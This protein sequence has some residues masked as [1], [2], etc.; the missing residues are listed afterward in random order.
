MDAWLLTIMVGVLCA[1][2]AL[3]VYRITGIPGPQGFQGAR[4]PEGPTGPK[5]DKSV[6]YQGATGPTG[7]TGPTGATGPN[8]IVGPRG[9]TGITGPTGSTGPTGPT[10]P[11]DVFWVPDNLTVMARGAEFSINATDS[12]ETFLPFQGP[13]DN[14]ACE[15]LSW[16]GQ[17]FLVGVGKDIY[18]L[19]G[20]Q[21]LGQTTGSIDPNAIDT[22]IQTVKAVIRHDNNIVAVGIPYANSSGI[23]MGIVNADESVTFTLADFQPK[24]DTYFTALA[25]ANGIWVACSNDNSTGDEADD[26][27]IWKTTDE[28]ILSG[29][30]DWLK[31]KFSILRGDSVIRRS[32]ALATDGRKWTLGTPLVSIYSA[33]WTSNDIDKWTSTQDP[34]WTNEEDFFVINLINAYSVAYNGHQWLAAGNGFGTSDPCIFYKD[35][36]D[37][38]WHPI[39]DSKIRPNGP[40]ECAIAWT[41][42]SWV[43]LSSSEF[44]Y[45]L[46]LITNN[47]IQNSITRLS[48]VSSPYSLCSNNVWSRRP[49]NGLDAIDT[50]AH[51]NAMAKFVPL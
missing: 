31:Y 42:V 49:V 20:Q 7:T 46:K 23:A 9:F 3:S 13:N 27:Y 24:M 33:L 8:G 37:A 6:G 35:D 16:E 10:G 39:D 41:G 51:S 2:I 12:I 19:G 43:V 50:V 34:T 28:Q 30:K 29:S 44:E 26:I 14:V 47:T 22:G 40:R 15:C 1:T 32:Y 36:G 11:L 18:T 5:G 48:L 45:E 25:Y 38:L 4:G 17:H 21:I